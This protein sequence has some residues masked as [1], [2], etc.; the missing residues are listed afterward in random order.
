MTADV[1]CMDR[2]GTTMKP[3]WV[4]CVIVILAIAGSVT[5]EESRP[6]IVGTWTATFSM[7]GVSTMDP[8]GEFTLLLCRQD[9]NGR[10]SGWWSMRE[11]RKW[12]QWDRRN[13]PPTAVLTGNELTW[14]DSG[15][16]W[17]RATVEGDWM[18]GYFG[19]H[20]FEP[21][22]F[23]ASKSPEPKPTVSTG[24]SPHWLV[25]LWE[26]MVPDVPEPR[27]IRVVAVEADG[28]A[29]GT[30]GV[31]NNR[32]GNAEIR[33]GPSRV[34]IVNTIKSVLELTREGQDR[35]VGTL[36]SS[37]GRVYPVTFVKQTPQREQDYLGQIQCPS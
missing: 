21:W 17:M 19:W 8:K 34:H 33:V 20:K 15:G 36:T 35:L 30:M 25:G 31:A 14:L 22:R 5:G 32:P 11:S 26:G 12:M 6:N 2:G 27:L 29:Q 1:G 28:K 37:G 13:I 24:A 4:V 23:T 7:V 16:G 10:V 3:P 9:A 18:R